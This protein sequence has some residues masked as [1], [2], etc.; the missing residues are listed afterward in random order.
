MCESVISSKKVQRKAAIASLIGA[1]IE[2]YD[3]LLYGTIATLVFNKLFF[4]NFDSTI[5]LLLSLASFG[6]PYFFRP[7]GGVLFSHI[8]DRAGR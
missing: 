2:Y 4:T 6:I 8:G 7:L 3:Y 1:S 5:G